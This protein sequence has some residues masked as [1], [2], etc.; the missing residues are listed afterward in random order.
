MER[1]LYDRPSIQH[2]KPVGTIVGDPRV[3]RRKWV[4][5]PG[6]PNLRCVLRV[7]GGWIDAR[8]EEL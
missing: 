4:P 5:Q 3:R 1:T 6:F 7:D 2:R 8:R